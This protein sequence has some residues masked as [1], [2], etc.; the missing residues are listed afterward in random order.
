MNSQPRAILPRRTSGNDFWRSPHKPLFLCCFVWA[1]LAIGWW[2]L[3]AEIGLPAPEIGSPVHW[4]VH[5]LLFGFGG[6]AL[7]G[8]LLTALPSWTA[9]KPM[10]RGCLRILVLFWVLARL[11]AAFAGVVP[12]AVIGATN[13]AYFFGLGAV[14]MRVTLKVRLYR[15]AGFGIA[16]LGLGCAEIA[17]LRFAALTPHDALIPI[18]TVAVLCFCL[19]IIVVGGR[20][21]PA[22]TRNWMLRMERAGPQVDDGSRACVLAVFLLIFVLVCLLVAKDALAH[23]AMI[24]CGLTLLRSMR[25]WRSTH[26]LAN[27]LLVSLHLA[28]LWVPIGMVAV[29]LLGLFP[30]A[31]PLSSALHAITVGA[32]SGMIMAIAGRAAARRKRGELQARQGFI[33]GVSLLWVATWVRLAAP[34]FSESSGQIIIVAAVMWCLSWAALL[35]DFLP[36]LF[37]PS[38]HPVLSGEKHRPPDREADASE[39]SGHPAPV[40]AGC[41]KVL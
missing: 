7:G 6:A 18:G 12:L 3:G 16:M 17:Y 29:G 31:Y 40:G 15:K 22:F 19:L 30:N 9:A 4:H 27:P 13:A 26:T 41:D 10:G 11:T 1:A 32:M 14:I 37:Q 24:V 36:G 35:A 34:M 8:Y 21:V 38:P 5:E 33:V 2:P 28:Y 23:I 20:A 25:G 39:V